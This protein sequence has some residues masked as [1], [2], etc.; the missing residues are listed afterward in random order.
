MYEKEVW[1]ACIKYFG[2]CD[3][4]SKLGTG[5]NN[6]SML[7]KAGR[8]RYVFRIGLRKE[9]EK[10]MRREFEYMKKLP[11][12]IG[13]EPLFFD[14]SKDIIPRV[15][16]VLSYIKGKHVYR[17]SE[18]HLKMHARKLAELHNKR[19]RSFGSLEK[20][21]HGSF[22]L[23]KKFKKDLRVNRSAFDN[24]I[25]KILPKVKEHIKKKNLLFMSL[26]KFSML[27]GDLCVDNILFS[28][29]RVRYI[30]WEW[31]KIGD[32]AED[33]ACFYKDFGF[34]PWVIKLKGK[35]LRLFLDTYLKYIKDETLK[36]RVEVWHIYGLFFT[37]VYFKWKLKNF[38]KE[39]KEFPKHHYERAVDVITA[40]FKRRFIY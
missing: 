5:E 30:D 18:R 23:F 15:Y 25:N 34:K 39:N 4:V 1:K 31:S 37:L 24:D 11:K 9:L 12:D 35:R 19:F 13:P 28:K 3:S 2:R 22:D 6:I 7:A 29:D 33:V 10:N 27:H 26:K 8:K 20:P 40:Y 16:S 38:H 36:Q 17:W 32:N 21:I 14:N